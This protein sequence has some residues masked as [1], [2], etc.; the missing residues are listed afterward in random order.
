MAANDLKWLKMME[1]TRLWHFWIQK[2]IC[3]I[4]KNKNKYVHIPT[5]YFIFKN[6]CHFWQYPSTH[7]HLW[8]LLAIFEQL[9]ATFANFLLLQATF[10]CFWPLLNA[11]PTR[12]YQG[13]PGT[14]ALKWEDIQNCLP[15]ISGCMCVVWEVGQMY[16]DKKCCRKALQWIQI[17]VPQEWHSPHQRPTWRL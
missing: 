11:T 8:L 12:A 1:R 16:W 5:M 3:A 14:R 9:L 15:R 6:C 4:S 7:A 2:Q 17:F 10:H 13:S